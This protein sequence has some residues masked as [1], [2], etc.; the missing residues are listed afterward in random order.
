M[1]IL[2]LDYGEKNMG[3][4]VSDPL[5]M[6]AGG[7]TVLKRESIKKD[8]LAIHTL[9]ETYQVE[10]VVLGLPL[11]MDGSKG[12]A[13]LQVEAFARRLQGRLRVPVALW[14]ERLS[15]VAAERALLEGEVSRRERG[16]IIDKMGAVIILQGYL[17]SGK[18][19]AEQ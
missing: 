6:T 13:A 15:T 5:G 9:V 1:R 7:L 11:N 16:K 18:A 19:G 8:L 14:D 2:A 4:A 3:V 17:D 10:K 12:P